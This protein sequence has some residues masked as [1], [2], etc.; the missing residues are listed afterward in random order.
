MKE[1][2]LILTVENLDEVINFYKNEVG[3]KES[4]S[5]DEDTGKGIIL[6]AGLASLEIID[7]NHKDFIDQ[8]EVGRAGVSGDIRIALNFGG[9]LTEKSEFLTQTG[10]AKKIG[11]ITKAPWSNVMRIEDPNGMQITLFDSSTITDK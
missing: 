8:M 6:E 10:A 5:W 3:L 2:R 9:K 1:L 7:R 4:L 11:E